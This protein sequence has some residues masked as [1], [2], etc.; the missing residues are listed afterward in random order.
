MFLSLLN[1]SK[2]LGD[3][4]ELDGFAIFVKLKLLTSTV[5]LF[6]SVFYI[7]RI[8]VGKIIPVPL[9]VLEAYNCCNYKLVSLPPPPP[10]QCH[11][12]PPPPRKKLP[13]SPMIFASFFP[14][15]PRPTRRIHRKMAAN[16]RENCAQEAAVRIFQILTHFPI[17]N[18]C[19]SRMQIKR[20]A[21][22]NADIFAA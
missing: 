3:H 2:Q 5:F 1:C 18:D 14:P 15:A 21:A 9:P 16:W 10:P 12:P 13:G 8:G 7:V 11:L 22:M 6:L 4:I 17:D 20:D 19:L